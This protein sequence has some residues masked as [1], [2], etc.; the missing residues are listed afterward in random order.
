M[1]IIKKLIIEKSHFKFIDNKIIIDDLIIQDLKDY[2]DKFILENKDYILK[3]NFLSYWFYLIRDFKKF[4]NDEEIDKILKVF[5]T[6]YNYSIKYADL[7]KKRFPEGELAISKDGNSSLIYAKIL[8]KRWTEIDNIDVGI[9]NTAE[10][11]I[12]KTPRAAFSYANEILKKPWRDLKDIDEE[13]KNI[14]EKSIL[15]D[16]YDAISYADELLNKRWLELEEKMLLNDYDFEALHIYI[17][18]IKKFINSRYTPFEDLLLKFKDIQL[19]TYYAK[20]IIG[21]RWP[22]AEKEMLRQKK[23]LE[24]L[25]LNELELLNPYIYDD[26]ETI[27]NKI[28]DYISEYEEYVIHD[29]L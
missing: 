9:A 11:N 24:E 18:Y 10:Y 12:A 28:I 29:S 23:C 27:E 14:A 15:K 16:S 13:I 22:E 19:M 4:L 21:D 25:E 8:K 17:D 5:K 6:T 26:L 1:K 3:S 2:N 7:I 20:T